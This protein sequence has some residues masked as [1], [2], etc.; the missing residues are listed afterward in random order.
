MEVY[1]FFTAV[2][3]CGIVYFFTNWWQKRKERLEE[4]PKA[5]VYPSEDT[6]LKFEIREDYYG[7]TKRNTRLAIR[8]THEDWV[9][10]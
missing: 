9:S 6:E 1:S 2:I 10:V 4:K 3:V 8:N 7:R 5:Y